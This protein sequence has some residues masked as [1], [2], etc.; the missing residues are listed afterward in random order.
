L[1]KYTFKQEIVEQKKDLRD[2]FDTRQLIGD[3]FGT[4]M[5]AD[6]VNA[7]WDDP[8]E[9][10]ELYKPIGE[11]KERSIDGVI[12]VTSK[13]PEDVETEVKLVRDHFREEPGSDDPLVYFHEER[14]GRALD[15]KKE[16]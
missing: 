1:G 8:Q 2:I 14:V 16:Q 7:G 6:L 15:C 13:T 9:I 5:Y 3:S 4:G 11:D 10:R 12:M